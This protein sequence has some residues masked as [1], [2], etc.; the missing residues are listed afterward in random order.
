M[1]GREAG[2][3]SASYAEDRRFKSA[4]RTNLLV[5]GFHKV[6]FGFTCRGGSRQVFLCVYHNDIFFYVP[7]PSNPS[8]L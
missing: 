5:I 7:P 2:I 4:L 6:S 8:F 3:S 1:R